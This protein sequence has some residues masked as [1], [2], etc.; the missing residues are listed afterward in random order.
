MSQRLGVVHQRWA[1]S[2]TKRAALVG[3]KHGQGSIR[4]DP[5]HQCRLLAGDKA[6]RRSY[7]SFSYV[8]VAGSSS[9]GDGLR[10]RCRHTVTAGGDADQNLA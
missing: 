6:V 9:L 8:A 3:T 7:D 4:I 1:L 5:I 10:Y 2:D